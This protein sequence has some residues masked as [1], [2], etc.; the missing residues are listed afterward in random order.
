MTLPVKMDRPWADDPYTCGAKP[1]D[2]VLGADARQREVGVARE[3]TSGGDALAQDR[4]DLLVRQFVMGL[5]EQHACT[6][7]GVTDKNKRRTI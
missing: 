4:G 1:V 6:V 2:Q 3:P 5:I 7:A